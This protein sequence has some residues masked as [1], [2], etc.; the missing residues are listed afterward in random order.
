M[1]KP[2]I[3]PRL[4][5]AAISL[6]VTAFVFLNTYEVVFNDDIPFANSIRKFETQDQ[7]NA[8]IKQFDIKPEEGRS[9]TNAPYSKLRY[10]Q[11]PAIA[12][13]LYLEEKRVINGLW[14]QRPSL[15][16]YIGLNKDDHDV[17]VDYLIYTSASWQT[18]RNPDQIEPG[19]DVKLVHDDFATSTFKVAEKK[20][21]PQYASF[22]AGKSQERQIILLIEDTANK[23]YYAFSLVLKE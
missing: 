4:A 12:T 20:V 5:L 7:I 15:G 6:L 18:I 8:I 21:L 13:N 10:L 9:E 1:S 14:Y 11:I 17:T 23:A 16:H 19:M 2:S 3:F 22:V